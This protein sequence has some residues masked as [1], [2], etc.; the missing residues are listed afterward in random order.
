MKLINKVEKI[1]KK[2]NF[3]KK[4]L[5]FLAQFKNSTKAFSRLKKEFL[6]YRKGTEKFKIFLFS[7]AI[8]I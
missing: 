1:L 5:E 4:D 3:T 7:L 6:K 2:N 8:E